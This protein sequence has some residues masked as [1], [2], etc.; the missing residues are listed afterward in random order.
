MFNYFSKI[1][2]AS[3]LF[4][5]EIINQNNWTC[6][7]CRTKVDIS[8]WGRCVVLLFFVVVSTEFQERLS[9]GENVYATLDGGKINNLIE[10]WTQIFEFCR[11]PFCPAFAILI[12]H[13][14]E[15]QTVFIIRRQHRNERCW[16]WWQTKE[17]TLTDL[18]YV[19]YNLF[20]CGSSM[21]NPVSSPLH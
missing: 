16:A 9:F 5:V 14:A 2:H 11:P 12:D 3:C 6:S 19:I 7:T 15:R 20:Q 17:K 13:W 8:M 10:H 21:L 1:M 18:V 4:I